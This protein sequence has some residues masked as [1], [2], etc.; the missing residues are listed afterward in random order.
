MVPGVTGRVDELE[1]AVPERQALAVLDHDHPVRRNRDDLAVQLAVERLAVD[2]DRARDQ[3]GRVDQVRRAARVQHRA[4]IRQRLHQLA[5][6][7]RMIEV[8][9]R[10]EQVVDLLARDADLVQ[11]REQPGCGR[12]GAGIDE[13]RAAVIDHEV[14]RREPRTQVEGI[15]QEDPAAQRLGQR[16]WRSRGQRP[17]H[18]PWSRVS[19]VEHRLGRWLE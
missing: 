3:P 15:D 18:F 10:Q 13:R 16:G 9:V 14:A 4:G 5:G 8:H 19:L 7:A 2:L 17:L 11:R 1:R 6:P 12:R